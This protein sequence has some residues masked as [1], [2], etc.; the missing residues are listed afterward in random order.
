MCSAALAGPE[1][2]WNACT[3]MDRPATRSSANAPILRNSCWASE[4]ARTTKPGWA[5][6]DW[7]SAQ[8]FAHPAVRGGGGP[9]HRN[10]SSECSTGRTRC[11]GRAS[12]DSSVVSR[13]SRSGRLCGWPPGGG[14]WAAESSQ[15]CALGWLPRTRVRILETTWSGA[16]K[17]ALWN[18]WMAAAIQASRRALPDLREPG[19]MASGCIVNLHRRLPS[20]IFLHR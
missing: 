8:R 7:R 6:R 12:G 15:G 18:C 19:F 11:D 4:L 3:A 1:S 5:R 17:R 14:P 2:T 9:S 16:P 20:E 10:R 13:A